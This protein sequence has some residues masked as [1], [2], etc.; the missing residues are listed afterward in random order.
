MFL[1]FSFY[2]HLLAP[3]LKTPS[4][5][6]HA[7]G[8]CF[9]TAIPLEENGNGISIGWEGS[10]RC[11]KRR[12]SLD[13]SPRSFFLQHC[14]RQWRRRFY[15]H[16]RPRLLLR[17][18]R[19]SYLSHLVLFF[20]FFLISFFAF[21]KLTVLLTA[22]EFT[23]LYLTL[24]SCLNSLLRR[25][26]LAWDSDSLSPTRFAPSRSY[27][28]TRFLNFFTTFGYGLLVCFFRFGNSFCCLCHL[29]RFLVLLDSL[30][31]SMC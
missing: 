30:T 12:R 9:A 11:R 21:G 22:G 2:F 10:S 28:K 5:S 25:N 31:C 3:S 7:L 20:L 16:L 6:S 8:F 4:S 19:S 13:R 18:R 26:S 14:R 24:S 27:A 29:R 1:T 17:R 23:R 15:Y